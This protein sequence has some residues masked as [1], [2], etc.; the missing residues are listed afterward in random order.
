MFIVIGSTDCGDGPETTLLKVL[1]TKDEVRPW[2][3][4]HLEKEFSEDSE[5]T[6]CNFKWNIIDPE[7]EFEEVIQ[8]HES[9]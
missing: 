8:V 3:E 1:E 2:V 5:I 4:E 9:P 6:D 7:L